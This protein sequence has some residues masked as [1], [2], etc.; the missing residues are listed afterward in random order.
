MAALRRL[1]LDCFWS[2]TP[3]TYAP[4]PSTCTRTRKWTLDYVACNL[5]DVAAGVDCVLLFSKKDL[6]RNWTLRE[7]DIA[8]FVAAQEEKSAERKVHALQISP[9]DCYGSST[10]PFCA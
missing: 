1:V 2:R 6:A 7:A 3:S 10:C 5:N 4:A 9:L 8:R